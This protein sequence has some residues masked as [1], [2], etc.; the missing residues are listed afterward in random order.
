M[1]VSL[2]LGGMYVASP[3]SG[4]LC[5]RFG[6]LPMIGAGAL[7]LIGAVLLAGLVPGSD[8]AL[9]ILGLFLNGVGWNFAFVAGS[10]LLTDAL[11]P[12]ERASIQ[13]LA[14]LVMGLMGAFGSA[15]GGMILGVWGFA[16]LNT[17]RRRP[18]AG[19]LAITLAAPPRPRPALDDRG[20]SSCRLAGSLDDALGAERGDLV[21]AS[22]AS[23]SDRISSVWRPS[24]AA[25]VG[26]APGCQRELGHD[27][28]LRQRAEP[29]DGHVDDHLARPVVR[30]G[31]DV[32]HAHDGRVRDVVRPSAPRRAFSK[33][34]AANHSV[35]EV[36]D[37]GDVLGPLGG[38]GEARVA[39]KL[40][41]PE[42]RAEPLEEVLGGRGEDDPPPVERLIGAARPARVL[43]VAALADDALP[44]VERRPCTP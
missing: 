27:A 33:G 41:L 28:G 37:D 23:S 9:V 25:A 1:A 14:D 31:E 6:R 3:L 15:A 39:R 30:V 19:P 16:I 32:G 44:A 13:G 29:L 22:C 10:A 18:G 26:D 21:A 42:H 43:E 7:V 20:L 36:E 40:G 17:R 4:W 34:R 12:A 24:A 8:H 35:I 38:A 11:S 5:D 2:H